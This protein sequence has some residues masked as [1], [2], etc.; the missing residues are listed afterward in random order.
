MKSIEEVVSKYG[1]VLVTFSSYYKYSFSFGADIEDGIHIGLSIGESADDIYRLSVNTNPISIKQLHT[2]NEITFI[3][4]KQG[5]TE[6]FS[7][8][9]Y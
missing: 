6:L 7:I 5:E 1:E 2:E 4:A 9:N 8:S 3:Y